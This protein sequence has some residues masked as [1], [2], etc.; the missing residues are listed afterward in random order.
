MPPKPTSSSSRETAPTRWFGTSAGLFFGLAL[1]KFGNPVILD[2]GNMYPSL[3]SLGE[4]I[5]EPWP[6][7]WGYALVV[8]LVV[9]GCLAAKRPAGVPRWV[10]W[11]PAVWFGWQMLSSAQSIDPQLTRW[12]LPHFAAATA[13]FYLGVFA[14][15]SAAAQRVW[16]GLTAGFLLALFSAVQQHHGGFESNRRFFEENEQTHWTNA[17]PEQVRDLEATRLLVRAPDGTL[18]I[19][20][21]MRHKIESTRVFGTL[22]YPNA[23]AGVILLLLPATLVAVAGWT[24]RLQNVTRGV[25]VGIV[26]YMGLGC[27]YWSGS[28]S[29]WLIALIMGAAA[30]MWLPLARVV[31]ITAVAVVVLAGAAGFAWKFQSYFE[32]GATSA[33]ARFDYWK[34]AWDSTVK[35][36]LL[37]T[38][39]GTFYAV[40]RQTKKPESEMARLTHNDY[41]QQASDSGV[42]G[43]FSYAA[44]LMGSLAVLYRKSGSNTA[45]FALWL[46]LFGW[47][48]QGFVEFGLYLPA[49]AWTAFFLLGSLWTSASERIGFD[50]RGSLH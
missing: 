9:L 41:L 28:K 3:K 16:V 2:V 39:P 48:L 25:L 45:L 23:L 29:G 10:L 36:P 27:L 19:N 20:P 7:K 1:L 12:T 24:D 13:C 30:L 14:G 11:M 17:A 50:T 44:L 8:G 5:F 26:A 31:K 43:F 35:H 6:V 22:V 42:P 33:T 49:T 15:G 32:K 40:Y 18:T 37:G 4:V 47:A 34:A 46:G 21:L 38:G